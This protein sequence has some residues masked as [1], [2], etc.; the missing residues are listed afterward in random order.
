MNA[1]QVQKMW[2]CSRRDGQ[3]VPHSCVRRER[4][5]VET[6]SVVGGEEETLKFLY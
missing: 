6:D 1:N 2:T 3:V 4:F 5:I